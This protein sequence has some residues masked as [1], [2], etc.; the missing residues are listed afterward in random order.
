MNFN[1]T[2]FSVGGAADDEP[3][4]NKA[5]NGPDREHWITACEEEISALERRGAF[6]VVA[7]PPGVDVIPGLCV[8]KKKRGRDGKVKRFK[9]R[10]VA[11]GDRQIHG[12]HYFET[13]APTM[14]TVSL[15]LFLAYIVFR[16][17]DIKFANSM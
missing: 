12:Q 5:M 10:G 3:N 13:F 8:F 16:G 15:R 4:F 14:R 9:A 1:E 2:A 17:W 11:Q 7:T 6:V